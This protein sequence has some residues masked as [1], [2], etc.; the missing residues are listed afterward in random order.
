MAKWVLGLTGGIGSGKSLA[1]DC[2]ASAGVDIVDADL[3][4]R[5][6]VAAGSPALAA[7]VARFGDDLL[8]AQGN[9]QR[10]RL[11]SIIFADAEQRHWLE[12]LLHPR[13]RDSLLHAL[14]ASTSAYTVLVSPLLFESGQAALCQ[15]TLLIDAP[16]SLQLT[17]TLAR[18]GGD[19]AQ[20]Q[21]IIASQWSRQQRCAA[22]D[23]I[24]L[25]D[26]SCAALEDQLMTLHQHYLEAAAHVR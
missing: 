9:L 6:V 23:D 11:R 17:R 12:A 19:V 13:I 26:G 1:S 25:N 22:A 16:E 3:C 21:A 15:R 8:D 10:R 14:A 4:A 20:V 7:I 5:D 2:L 18:D 24:L